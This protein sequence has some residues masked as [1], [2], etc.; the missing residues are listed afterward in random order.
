MIELQEKYAKMIL[1]VCLLVKKNQPLF[2]S[3]N[4]ENRDFVR[5]VANE[6]YKL[7]VK[8]IYFDLIDVDLKHDMLKNLEV[9]D[10]K[11]SLYFDKS[12]YNEYAKKGAA[13]I[14]LASETPGLM[15]DIDSKKQSDM[16]VYSLETKKEFYDLSD[17]SIVPWCI[18]AVPTES[19][20]KKVFPESLN[21]KEDLWYKIF[22][23]CGVLEDNSLE[24][25]KIKLDKL[26]ERKDKL[27]SYNFKK[28]IYTNSL[29]T[30]FTIELP[31]NTLW[32]TGRE[33]L[34]NGDEVLVNYP[35]EEVFTSPNCESANGIVYSSK[36]LCYQ[37][38]LV[39]NFWIKFE[40]GIV[41]DYGADEGYETLDRLIN[42][43]ENSN[44]LGEIALVEHNSSISNSN[45]IFYTTLYDENASCHLA[46]GDS[47]AE[48]IKDGI[49]MTEEQL[50][51][52]KLNKCKSH[53]DFM[54]GTKD[55]NIKGITH[56]GNEV[57]I[58][59]N[60]NFSDIFE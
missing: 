28:L 5:I 57:D 46:L 22:E 2:I 39:N 48:C 25:L 31:E 14:M 18:A 54:I 26:I 13:F 50:K 53:T 32:A 11:K 33:K 1:N 38:N 15:N 34:V 10:L 30:N 27:N 58:F 52:N 16:A 29:G 44:K 49:N 23:I 51:N 9:D 45:I 60:G 24:Y 43:C 36:P 40:N 19:W 12:I 59:I 47:F 3:S 55:L 4:V 56:D 21:P 41:V 35:T 6:A 8:E 37:D 42:L 20:A 17:K 7:G